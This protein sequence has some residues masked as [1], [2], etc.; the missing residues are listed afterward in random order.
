MSILGDAGLL[1]ATVLKIHEDRTYP[2]AVVA[3]LE[4]TLGQ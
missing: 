3:S 1:S 2:G 4:C